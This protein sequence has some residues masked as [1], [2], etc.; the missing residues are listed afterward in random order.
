MELF[1]R[2]LPDLEDSIDSRHLS[3]ATSNHTRHYCWVSLMKCL[4]EHS[5]S[6]LQAP[7]NALMAGRNLYQDVHIGQQILDPAYVVWS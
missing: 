2:P 6:H 7:W 1:L 3:L 4:I 5:C